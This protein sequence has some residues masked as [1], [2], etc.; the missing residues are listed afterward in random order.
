VNDDSSRKLRH[1]YH[2]QVPFDLDSSVVMNMYAAIGLS[3]MSLPRWAVTDYVMLVFTRIENK[4]GMPKRL[5]DGHSTPGSAST[6]CDV[7]SFSHEWRQAH[8]VGITVSMYG[9]HG[10]QQHCISETWSQ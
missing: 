1:T 3:V 5:Q 9:M 4:G 10:K 6:S 7:A 2:D 8:P